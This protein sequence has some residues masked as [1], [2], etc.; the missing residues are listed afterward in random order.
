MFRRSDRVND[1]RISELVCN[2]SPM[3]FSPRLLLRLNLIAKVLS[4]FK[5]KKS[6]WRVRLLQRS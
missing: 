3:W 4:F 1:S 6:T 5:Y 2:V